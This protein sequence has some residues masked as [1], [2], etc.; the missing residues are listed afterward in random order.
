MPTKKTPPRAAAAAAATPKKK[1]SVTA[2]VEDLATDFSKINVNKVQPDFSY[3]CPVIPV[4]YK[5]GVKHLIKYDVMYPSVNSA[6][7]KYCR[8]LPGGKQVA[9]LIAMPRWPTSE[10]FLK[11]ELKGS[12]HADDA[13]VQAR[14]QQITHFVNKTIPARENF[15][16]GNPQIIDLPFKCVEGDVKVSWYYSPL[17]MPKIKGRKN[18]HQ[19]FSIVMQFSV[20][21][22]DQ[23]AR[24][25]KNNDFEMVGSFS[26]SDEDTTNNMN[27]GP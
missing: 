7:L 24:D 12:W 18:S 2:S 21:S 1:P 25:F 14:S 10:A 13:L 26:E 4:H 15:I 11:E 8:V 6:C 17:V 16:S 19:Q 20:E 9:F 23:Y 3:H 5:K 22:L 27:V